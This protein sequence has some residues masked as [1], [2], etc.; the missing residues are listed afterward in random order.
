LEKIVK[1]HGRGDWYG[2]DF[3]FI[4][5]FCKY[6][7]ESHVQLPEIPIGE[8]ETIVNEYLLER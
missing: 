8:L 4:W 7:W 5:A 6:F 1:E 2:T 3:D